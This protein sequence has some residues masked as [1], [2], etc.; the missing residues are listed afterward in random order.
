MNRRELLSG[1]VATLAA[2]GVAASGEV[3]EAEPV[4]GEMVT[5]GSVDLDKIDELLETWQGTAKFT[6][7]YGD[8]E[9]T[10]Y[11]RA[12]CD[13]RFLAYRNCIGDIRRALGLTELGATE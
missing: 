13:G 7:E 1:L 2:G 3:V 11:G 9:T 8:A 5:V 4:A 10:A 12:F 6:R